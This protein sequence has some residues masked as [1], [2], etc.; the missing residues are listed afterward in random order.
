MRRSKTVT[1]SIYVGVGQVEVSETAQVR[2]TTDIYISRDSRDL[3]KKLYSQ[4]KS[5]TKTPSSIHMIRLM[6]A[7]HSLSLS[8]LTTKT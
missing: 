8:T 7:D 1:T 5:S 2:S 6:N 3:I 4:V